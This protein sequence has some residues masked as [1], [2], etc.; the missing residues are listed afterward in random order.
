MRMRLVNL[1]PECLLDPQ[2]HDVGQVRPAI[3]KRGEGRSGYAE[4]LRRSSYGQRW[5][6][7]TSVFGAVT[8][9]GSNHPP[10]TPQGSSARLSDSFATAQA[11]PG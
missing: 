5:G 4:H 10:K 1:H 3:Q 7:I 9:L 6:S 8:L 11:F 2:R